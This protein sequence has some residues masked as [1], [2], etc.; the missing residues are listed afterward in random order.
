MLTIVQITRLICVYER[1]SSTAR[2]S[3]HVQEGLNHFNL[4][5]PILLPQVQNSHNLA[6]RIKMLKTKKFHQICQQ[7]SSFSRIAIQN[8]T[9]FINS[10]PVFYGAKAKVLKSSCDVFGEPWTKYIFVWPKLVSGL[11]NDGIHHIQT[12]HLI[13]RLTLEKSD[14]NIQRF[15]ISVFPNDK[16]VCKS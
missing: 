7:L 13:L 15:Q 6:L 2:A 12:C 16:L 11:P 9:C 1:C 10:Y 14:K 5:H 8:L 4:K 3:C